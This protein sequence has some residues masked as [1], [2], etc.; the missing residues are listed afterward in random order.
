[1]P[2]KLMHLTENSNDSWRDSEHPTNKDVS[3]QKLHD[4]ISKKAIAPPEMMKTF[5]SDPDL[6]KSIEK[7]Q[8]NKDEFKK[9]AE[10]VFAE[11]SSDPFMNNEFND[12]LYTPSLDMVTAEHEKFVIEPKWDRNHFDDG[13]DTPLRV[14]YHTVKDMMHGHNYTLRKLGAE[15]PDNT[16]QKILSFADK[17][18]QKVK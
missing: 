17:Y 4:L 18:N 9:V 10:Q 16:L 7:L 5:L 15:S 1:M 13:A 12:P 8:F 14:E 3:S 11:R 6:A 2:F